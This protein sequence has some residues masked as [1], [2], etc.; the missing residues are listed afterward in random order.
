MKKRS[1]VFGVIGLL[2]TVA[3]MGAFSQ[4]GEDLFQKALRLE[5]NEGKL[6]EAIELYNR[7]VAEGKNESLAAQA[8][9]R[10]GLCYEKLGQNKIKQAQ[11]AFQK[12]IDNYPGQTEAVKLAKEKLSL[13]LRAK[14]VIEEGDKDFK[15]RQV[16]TGPNVNFFAP[17]PDGRYLS[18]MDLKS[19]NLAVLELA[20]KKKRRLTKKG[21]LFKSKSIAGAV[22]SIWSPDSR[23]VAYTWFNYADG[24]CDLRII[25]IDGPK[26][27][28]LYQNKEVKYV[29]PFDWSPDGKHI[30][31][32]FIRKDETAQ[33]ALISVADG[34]VRDLKTFDEPP[35]NMLKK[36]LFS[37][38]GRYIVYDLIPKQ[39]IPERDIFLLSTDGTREITLIENPADDFVLGWAPDGKGLLFA[40]DRTGTLD[41]W[42]ICVSQGK[43]LGDPECIKKD[44]GL[45]IF[46]MGFTKNG[47]YYYGLSAG[48]GGVYIATLDPEKGKLLDPPTRATQRFIGSNSEPK[49]SPDGKYLAFI[50]KRVLGP[51]REGYRVRVLCIRS[52]ETG[53]VR[54]FFPGL[55]V[56]GRLNRWS[57]DSRYV[58]VSGCDYKDRW[59]L[60]KIDSQTGK[61]TPNFQF[62]WEKG[63]WSTCSPNGKKLFYID[64]PYVYSFPSPFKK[65]TSCILMYDPEVG[66]EKEIYNE[67]SYLSFSRLS[68]DGRLLAFVKADFKSQ[69]RVLKI[70]PAEG[71]EPREVLRLEGEGISAFAWTS[72]GRWL[73]F[74]KMKFNEPKSELWRVSVEGGKPQKLGL[75][76]EQLN[77]LSI[78]PDGRQIAFYAGN[79]S[80]E[81]WVMENFLPKHKD[82]K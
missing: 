76:M 41:A 12:V 53:K 65:K 59:G 37:P 50:S 19:G 21:S 46:P 78:H 55:K 61:V 5:R 11:K 64:N 16:W 66:K 2:L 49:W 6:M 9:L 71:G 1:A 39:D 62:E 24:F 63:K 60:Y 20:T 56:F 47:S 44:L 8:Q 7:V 75:E 74:A 18:Y 70:M 58:F 36:V 33:L 45:R 54:E 26:P 10:V 14:T 79:E 30:L 28:V 15:I 48:M 67:N 32:G 51:E 13:I 40:S 57:P 4:S 82:R 68:P 52:M 22:G 81:I 38:D 35:S 31:A 77:Y 73:Y 17:S 29:H 69:V 72:D 25:G 34:S 3:L 42:Y 23:Q 43:P 80:A 27:R